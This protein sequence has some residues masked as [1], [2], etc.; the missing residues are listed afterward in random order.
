MVRTAIRFPIN[1]GR[2]LEIEKQDDERKGLQ[3]RR[4]TDERHDENQ[5]DAS[6]I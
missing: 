4:E 5:K 3:S 6:E 1:S 2:C